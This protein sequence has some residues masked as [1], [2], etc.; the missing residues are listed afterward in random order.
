SGTASSCPSQEILLAES[1][2]FEDDTES[3]RALLERIAKNPA[4]CFDKTVWP[5]L[6]FFARDYPDHDIFPTQAS[7]D[8]QRPDKQNIADCY[9]T[10]EK[11]IYKAGPDIVNSIIR[12]GGQIPKID[13]AFRIVPKGVQKGLKPVK[14]LGEFP[15]DPTNPE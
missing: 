7:F 4:L 8:D 1:V 15:F 3:V 9:V 5:D 2:V 14:L 10:S 13:K 11:P 12:N 6:R